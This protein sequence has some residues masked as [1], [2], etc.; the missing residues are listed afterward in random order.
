MQVVVFIL[1]AILAYL[2]KPMFWGPVQRIDGP[3]VGV[4]IVIYAVLFSAV[5]LVASFM[6]K[7]QQ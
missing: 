4:F 3:L 1:A 5:A 7:K 6:K 2:I